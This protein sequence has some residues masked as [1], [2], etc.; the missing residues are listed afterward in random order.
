[1]SREKT[2]VKNTAIITVG[3]ICTQ[4][5][6]FFLLPLYTALLSTEEYGTVDLLNTLVSLMLPIVTFQIEQAVFRRLIDNRNK[7]EEIKKIISTTV[8]T[9]FIQII[10]YVIL[11]LL[12][13]PFINNDYKYFLLTNVMACIFSS[14]MLQISR[15][16][17]D[18][19][20]YAI[21]SF[22]TASSTVLLN[23]VFIVIC[24]F[25]AYGMLMANLCGNIFCSLYIFV[26]KKIYKYISIKKWDKQLLK[27]MWKYSLPLIPNAISWWIFNSSDRIIVTYVL[28][29]GQNG[30]LSASYKFSNLY[31]TIYNIF[32]MTWTESASLHINDK[33]ASDFL[34]N[35]MNIV[36]KIFTAICFGIIGVMPFV[37]PIMI[38]E[39]FGESY[40]QIPILML[41]TLFNVMV[42]LLS[43]IYIAK[44]NTKAVAKTSIMA[45]IINLVV[46][47]G[48]IKFVGLYAAS[49]STLVAYLVMA[50]YRYADVQKFVKIRVDKKFIIM[51]FIMMPIL[52]I[53]Y[54]INNIYLNIFMLIIVCLY[55]LLT[56]LKTLNIVFEFIKKKL[57]LNK[58][59][60]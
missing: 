1:M 35:T 37:F 21:G 34:S 33:D 52:L 41:A 51:S 5:I 43:V 8:C 13:S 45:A 27:T 15:G 31:T 57:H 50:I 60:E 59:E 22:I 36:L 26:V 6:S 53:S 17:G 18:N 24:K 3:K 39:K 54:Y 32:N 56:N 10:I 19:K 4:M 44:K 58:V 20:N 48:L 49:I 55:A 2:L 23:V 12:V 7:D 42:G 30:I 47:F 16:L 14:I 40:Y 38:N 25:G 11:F 46:N 29:I 28:G 9:I